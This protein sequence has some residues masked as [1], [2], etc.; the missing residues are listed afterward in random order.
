MVRKIG[1]WILV[2][3][4]VIGLSVPCGLAAKKDKV[5]NMKIS[6]DSTENHHRNKGLKVFRLLIEKNSKGRINVQYYHSAQLYKDRDIPKAMK[7]GTVEMAAPGIWILEGVDPNMAITALP[8]FYGLPEHISKELIDGEVGDLLTESLEKKMNVKVLGKWLYHG[9]M[10]V[11][12]K[13]RPI[14]KI[15]D[16]NGL[17]IRHPGGASNAFK[18]KGFGSSPV[19][20]PWPDLS[21]AIIQG[22]ADGFLTTF[23]SFESAKLWETG[24]VY[25]TKDMTQYLQYIPMVSNKFWKSLPEDLQKILL[26]TWEEMVD[27]ERAISDYEQKKGETVMKKHGVTIYYPSAEQ[28]AK[29]REHIMPVQDQIIEKTGMDKAFVAKVQKIVDEALKK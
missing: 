29:W 16:W 24:A 23:K 10:N 7:L 4:L 12:T 18:L 19:M 3:F 6:L 20:I 14:L 17:K 1:F 11:C 5:Y 8:M 15:E 2:V 27:T 26:D 9:Y 22:T 28:L 25:A 21:M 13:T